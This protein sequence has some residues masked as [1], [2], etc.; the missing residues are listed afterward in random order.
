MK[1][2]HSGRIYIRP[3]AGIV[4]IGN[5]EMMGGLT[6]G[7]GGDPWEEGAAK[8]NVVPDENE[9]NE[10]HRGKDVWAEWDD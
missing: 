6:T 4:R 9:D 3:A 1:G 2:M 5:G 7:S 8:E 10:G